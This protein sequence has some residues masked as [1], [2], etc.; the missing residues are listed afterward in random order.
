VPLK[1]LE[2]RYGPS[3]RQEVIGELMRTS[4]YDAIA[5]EKLT[6]AGTPKIE[7]LNDKPGEAFDYV[8][9]IEIYPTVQLGNFNELTLE[10]TTATVTDT[11]IQKA[12]ENIRK[13]QTDWHKA[14]RPAADGDRLIIDYFGTIDS[15][16][17][18]GNEDKNVTIIIGAKRMIAG[19]EEGLIGAKAGDKLTLH[20]QFPEQY[21]AAD[22]A[23]KAVDFDITVHSV[24]KPTLPEID[25]AFFEKLGI[26]EGTLE[27]LQEE[28]QKT[29]QKGLDH[30]LKTN[31]KSHVMDKLLALHTFPVPNSLVTQ[32]AE[33]LRDEFINQLRQYQGGQSP[34]LPVDM[35]KDRAQRRVALGLLLR[36]I[37]NHHQLKADAARVRA[38]VE[39]IS[40]SYENPQQ[41]VSW[42][43]HN[44]E[45]MAEIES[46]ALEEQIVAL[47]MKD[48]KVTEKTAS[49]DEV[50]NAPQA[51]NPVE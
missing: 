21:H 51:T 15:K 41:V 7:S 2:Q 46:L 1:V 33:R 9:A 17:F 48:A 36:E 40:A 18:A 24:D 12:I 31:L 16:P 19:F 28:T 23:G 8:A 50:M 4:L 13:Q 22:L 25:A 37:I 43:Y 32:E 30:R 5:Q 6:I 38:L 44:K 34:N 27:K 11:D 3:V 47:V 35:F 26:K 14:D 20:L 45:R 39:D 42:F 49:F 29:L 10:Q